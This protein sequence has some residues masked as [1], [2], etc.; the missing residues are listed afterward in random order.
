MCVTS[1]MIVGRTP[2]VQGHKFVSLFKFGGEKMILALNK[3]GYCLS[4]W[5]IVGKVN[6]V[7][8]EPLPEEAA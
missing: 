8:G 4:R 3:D 2:S 6:E 1:L 5:E 7:V